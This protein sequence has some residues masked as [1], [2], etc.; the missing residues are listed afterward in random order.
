VGDS[1][2]LNL[3]VTDPQALD[4]RSGLALPVLVTRVDESGV[5]VLRDAAHNHEFDT[6]FTELKRGSDARGKPRYFHGVCRFLTGSIRQQNGTRQFGVYDTALPR[7][8]HHADILAPPATRQDLE[9]RKKHLIYNIGPS[10]VNVAQFRDGVFVKYA[11]DHAAD[12]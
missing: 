10:F 7:R 6:T 8:P 9:A 12:G 11:R 4:R 5:S 1:E 3:I 2:Y